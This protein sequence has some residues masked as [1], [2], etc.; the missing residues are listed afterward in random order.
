MRTS[1]NNTRLIDGH[2]FNRNTTEDALVF[3]ALLIINPELN[4]QIEWQKKAHT[5]IKLY[6]RKK[7]KSEIDTVHQKLF[8]E[9]EHL[10]FRQKILD[11][12]S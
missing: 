12:F 10:S 8:N 1:L 9:P 3:D 2:L 11:F 5:I 4:E 6:G 7:L